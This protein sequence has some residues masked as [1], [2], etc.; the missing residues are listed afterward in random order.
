MG[1]KVEHAPVQRYDSGWFACVKDTMY[2]KRHNFYTPK[3]HII[4]YFTDDDGGVPHADFETVNYRFMNGA[5][6]V[7]PAVGLYGIDGRVD[8]R[9][10]EDK[11]GFT[12]WGTG[13]IAF[14]DSGW[15]RVIVTKAV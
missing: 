12:V 6:I 1:A 9:A 14:Y 3:Q 13:A 4:V 2:L 11:A 8:I 10:G 15:Y 5:A 7:G